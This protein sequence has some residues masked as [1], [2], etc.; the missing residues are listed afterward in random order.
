MRQALRD[1]VRFLLAYVAVVWV[2][3]LVLRGPLT[4]AFNAT[5]IAG[6]LIDF[7]CLISGPTWFFI[8]LLFLANASFNNLSFPILSTLFNWGRATLGTMPFAALGAHLA[9]PKGA[10]AGVGI[11]AVLFGTGA[12]ATAFRTIDRLERPLTFSPPFMM[13]GFP[14]HEPVF[15]LDG[16]GHGQ[17]C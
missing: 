12:I 7:F 1:G 15:G 16:S 3:L 6:D 11:G 5:G 10:L 9:G 2:L 4:F 13:K 17:P 8:G 14:L